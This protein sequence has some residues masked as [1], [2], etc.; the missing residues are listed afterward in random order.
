MRAEYP[1]PRL[2]RAVILKNIDVFVHL[3]FRCWME[4]EQTSDHSASP[5]GKRER[6]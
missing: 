4:S 2:R 3:D 1:D 5:Y 6:G